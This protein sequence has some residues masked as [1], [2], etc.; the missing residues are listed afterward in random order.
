MEEAYLIAVRQPISN[1]SQ[2]GTKR[3]TDQRIDNNKPLLSTPGTNTSSFSKAVN[4]RTLNIEEMNEKRAK[5]LYYFS[6][7]KCMHGHK[8]KNSKQLYLLKVEELEEGQDSMQEQVGELQEEQN[9]QLELGPHVEHMEISM[10]ALN[11]PL[12]FRTLKQ[13]GCEVKSIKPDMVAAANGNMQMDKMIYVTWLLQGAE[14][15][16]DFLLLP[17]CSYGVVL[18][19]QWLLTLGDI[20]LNFRSLTIEGSDEDKWHPLDVATDKDLEENPTLLEVLS[21]SSAL[22]E[23]P[24][25]LPPSKGVFDHKIVLHSGA[26]PVNKRPY[27]YP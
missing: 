4:R 12:G 2:M 10:H 16:A 13:L 27:R 3:L 22:F 20:K 18:G 5:G 26:E 15:S 23:E 21:E 14:F 9:E 1:Q 19:I 11:G 6:N 7:E 8:C 17:I 24:V 25:G